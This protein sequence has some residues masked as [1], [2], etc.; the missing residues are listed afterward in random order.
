MSGSPKYSAVS[1][2]ASLQLQRERER[3]QREDAERKR[4][5][6]VRRAAEVAERSRQAASSAGQLAAAQAELERVQHGARFAPSVASDAAEL[7]LE[8]A[9]AAQLHAQGQFEQSSAATDRVAPRLAEA[10]AMVEA[11]AEALALRSATVEALAQGLASRGYTVGQPLAQADGTV[12]IRADLAGAAGVD[13]AIVAGADGNQ[14]VLQ[15]HGATSPEAA[16]AAC[17]SLVDLH[18]TLR[19][20]LAGE[21]IQLGDLWWDDESDQGAASGAVPRAGQPPR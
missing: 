16:A 8:L 17:P 5:Q 13:V 3:Q 6:A 11:E 18:G 19:R 9:K 15:R 1:Y 21:G 10:R 14:L 7:A 2:S 20:D 12:A 4:V